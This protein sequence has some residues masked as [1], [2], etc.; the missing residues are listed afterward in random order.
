MRTPL[1]DPAASRLWSHRLFARHCLALDQGRPYVSQAFPPVKRRDLLGRRRNFGLDRIQKSRAECAV[2]CAHDDQYSAIEL[3]RMFGGDDPEEPRNPKEDY[4]LYEAAL[5]WAHKGYNV[6]PQKAPDKKHPGVKWRDLQTRHVTDAELAR[7]ERMFANGVGFITGA[8]SGVIVIETDGPAGEALL[9]QFEFRHGELPKTLK[10]LSGSGRGSHRHFRHPGHRVKTVAN[11]AIKVDVKGDGGFCILPPSLHKSGGR[12]VIVH[13]AEPAELPQGLLEF[14]EEKARE[15]GGAQG[16]ARADKGMGQ[17]DD[18]HN[19]AAAFEHPRNAKLGSKMGFSGPPPSAETMRAILELL[20]AK[21]FFEHRSDI[22]NDAEGRIIK[23][24]WLPS[25]MALKVAYGDEV[26]CELWA[27]THHDD[28][29]RRD[30]PEQW[31]SFASEARAGHVTLGTIIKAAE[32]AGFAFGAATLSASADPSTIEGERFTGQGADVWNGKKFAETFRRRLLHIHETRE[33]LLFSPEQGWVAAPPGEAERAAKEVLATL[34]DHAAGRWTAN[35]L[36]PVA[37]GLMRHV[38]R[39]SE[40]KNIRAMIDMAKSE[41]GMTS[42]LCEFDNDPMLLGVAN[43]VLDLKKGVLLPV[44]PEVL[45]SKRCNVAFDPTTECERF[46]KF[47]TEV[48]PDADVRLFLQ[49][50]M[51]YCLTGRV[52]AQVFAF[53]YGHGANGK[54]VF[55]EL[56]GWLLGDYARKIPTEMLMHHQRNPQGP[57]PDIVS[58]KGRRF[59]Y[60]NETEEG[61]RLAEARVKELTG[62]DTLTGR[63]P[64]GKADITFVPTHKLIVVGN[65]KPEITDTSAGMWRRVILAPFDQTIPEA[66][67]DPKLLDTLKGEGP[68]F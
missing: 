4:G 5:A 48:Q 27:I 62:G 14:I 2:M 40:A 38:E 68:E 37:K 12:Y 9:E 31:K 23:L 26:G 64:Y 29:A 55:V 63:V 45:V 46:D 8:I 53:L 24:G 7:W 52:D 16:T 49:R 57:S 11:P 61:R 18:G 41:P 56:F 1:C 66:S 58:L 19:V 15:A 3:G 33:W 36:D 39:T 42:Q 59:V 65:H 32:D 34:R 43:G 51:G 6:V 44:S 60:A 10:I 54:S 30:A 13:D 17:T 35:P 47:M 25:G 50:L 20:E 21:D 67:R 28:E 22:L